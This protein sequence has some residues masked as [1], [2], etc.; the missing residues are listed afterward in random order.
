ML[1]IRSI[2]ILGAH[3]LATSMATSL[4]AVS[5]AAYEICRQVWYLFA[6]ALDALAVAAVALVA[7]ALR[8]EDALR[9]RTL[10]NRLLQVSLH[11]R[12]HA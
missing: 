5:G 12:E 3:S 9:C 8:A 1:S 7:Q 10:C 4:G 2:A 6:M 11:S